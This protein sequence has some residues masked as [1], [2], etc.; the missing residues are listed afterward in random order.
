MV[1]HKSRNLFQFVSVILSASV[2]RVGVSRMRDF[3]SSF[4]VFHS[5]YSNLNVKNVKKKGFDKKSSFRLVIVKLKST[6]SPKLVEVKILGWSPLPPS[7]EKKSRR[8]FVFTCNQKICN[9]TLETKI[10]I[11]L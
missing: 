6:H 9:L 1:L 4:S 3:F 10:G 2:E 7:I 5:S 8:K 11:K